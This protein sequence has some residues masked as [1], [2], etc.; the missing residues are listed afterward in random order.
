MSK[1]SLLEINQSQLDTTPVI[2]GQLIVCLDTGNAYR[3]STVAHVKIGSDLEVV[4]ELPLAPLAGKIYLKKP[5]ELYSYAGGVW[6]LLNEECSISA[7]KSAA[8]GD[9]KIMLDG[10]KQSSVAVKGSGVTTVMTNEEGELVIDTKDPS[11]YMERMTNTE[12]DA[13]LAT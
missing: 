6:T 8:N 13:I 12:I 1:L 11:I 7:N 10:A 5:N 9:V 3:D 2:D 4:S